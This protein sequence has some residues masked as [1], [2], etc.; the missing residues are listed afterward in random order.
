MYF[1]FPDQYVV[2]G[3]P[4]TTKIL[5]EDVEQE[6]QH[7]ADWAQRYPQEQ[8]HDLG[9]VLVTDVNKP[10]GVAADDRYNW[11]SFE[12]VG[13]ERHWTSAPKAAEMIQQMEQGGTNAKALAYLASTDWYVTRFA[14]TGE[15]I[16]LD[17]LDNRKAARASVVK[18]L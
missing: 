4:F 16:P 15:L 11:I 14:E 1:I 5:V 10:E 12:L 18:V 3:S 2:E 13:A 17:V 8:L 9:M 7:P 6:L